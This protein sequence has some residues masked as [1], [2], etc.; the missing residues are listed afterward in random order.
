MFVFTSRVLPDAAKNAVESF[1]VKIK[2]MYLKAEHSKL[3]ESLYLST[4][5]TLKYIYNQIKF[6]RY[7]KLVIIIFI[8][9]S[10][11][12]H[13]QGGNLLKLSNFSMVTRLCFTF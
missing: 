9:S 6:W 1:P 8:E 7:L 5:N 4:E 3:E 11:T 12:E 10:V 13:N 2:C